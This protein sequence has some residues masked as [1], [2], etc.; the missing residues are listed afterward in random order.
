LT[1]SCRSEYSTFPLLARIQHGD[2][3]AIVNGTVSTV[4]VHS[5]P[6]INQTMP[7]IIHILHFSGRLVAKLSQNLQSTGFRLWQFGGHKCGVSNA[8]WLVSHSSCARRLFKVQTL[9]KKIA[10]YDTHYRGL[11]CVTRVSTSGL[12]R[13]SSPQPCFLQCA[14]TSVCHSHAFGGCFMFLQLTQ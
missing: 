9:P 7:Q 4:L 2:V 6:H 13:P 11:I 1:N 8:R 14:R 5:S 12:L 10:V 3:S